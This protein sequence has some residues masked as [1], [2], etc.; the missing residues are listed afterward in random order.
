MC[1]D[2]N[3]RL[4]RD[5]RRRYVYKVVRRTLTGAPGTWE[6]IYYTREALYVAG[7][8]TV[9]KGCRPSARAPDIGEG[10]IHVFPVLHQAAEEAASL[11]G[12]ACVILCRVQSRDYIASG[13]WCEMRSA[14]YRAVV[15]LKELKI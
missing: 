11:Q 6:P 5:R 10:A 2:S 9:A 15:P 8:R 7:E 1:Q 4:K 14:C 12:R 3:K 13:L